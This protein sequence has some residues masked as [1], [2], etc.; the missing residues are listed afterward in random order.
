[1]LQH[2]IGYHFA[3]DETGRNTRAGYGKLAGIKQVMYFFAS[4]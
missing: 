3:T 2:F 4:A 1:M